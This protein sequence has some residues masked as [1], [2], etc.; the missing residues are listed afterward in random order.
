[1]TS[2]TPGFMTFSEVNFS[3]FHVAILMISRPS[4][5]N[6]Y[7]D[8]FWVRDDFCDNGPPICTRSASILPRKLFCRGN[9]R[10]RLYIAE[11]VSPEFRKC[12][13]VYDVCRVQLCASPSDR[14]GRIA[15]S[16]PALIPFTLTRSSR[17]WNGPLRSRYMT[18][19]S[20]SP[21]DNPGTRINWKTFPTFTLMQTVRGWFCLELRLL[22]SCTDRSFRLLSVDPVARRTHISSRISI[23][24]VAPTPETNARSSTFLKTPIWRRCSTILHAMS[25]L[26]PGSVMS[27]SS[28][29]LFTSS[30]S[31]PDRYT[32]G[33]SLSLK[34]KT[35]LRLRRCR[36]FVLGVLEWFWWHMF[37]LSKRGRQQLWTI[38]MES[39]SHATMSRRWRHGSVSARY[40]EMARVKLA[41]YVE[42]VWK[43][44]ISILSIRVS[45]SHS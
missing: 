7:A 36:P 9:E 45:S 20:A 35:A 15:L 33:V 2:R 21:C 32:G 24:F 10:G 26:I 6:T 3:R 40:P 17:C 31:L 42:H 30:W 13:F 28:V 12:P 44:E 11:S 19:F 38:P 34:L 43:T 39:V 16:T 23:S 4:L 29:A 5:W 41:S 8:D 27:C 25:R 22:L 37:G 14:Y 18:T 1:M